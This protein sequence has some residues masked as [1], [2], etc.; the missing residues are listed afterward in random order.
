V[1]LQAARD[2]HLPESLREVGFSDTQV[3]DALISIVNRC[4]EPVSERAL[5]QWL[6]TSALGD[7]WKEDLENLGRDRFYRVSDALLRV[8][9]T[10]EEKLAQREQS[11][12]GLER[13]LY[14]Y[15]LTNTYF[16]GN[17]HKN[18]AAKRGNSKEKRS[19]NPLMSVGLVLDGDGFVVRHQSL[20]GNVY[21]A[22]TLLE[23]VRAVTK[24]SDEKPLIIMDS[25]FS[26]RANLAALRKEGY[27]YVTVAKRP[28]RLAYADE[29]ADLSGFRK[30]RGRDSRFSRR[31]K[32]D[33]FV[34]SLRE[35]D[36]T[37]LCVYS[38]DRENKERA[39]F[40]KAET[41]LLKDLRKLKENIERGRLINPQTIQQRIGRI[42][43]RYPRAA[44]FYGVDHDG[45]NRTLKWNRDEVK[46]RKAM[47][48]TGGYIIR[49]NRLDLK[50]E[51]LWKIYIL[52][53]KVEAGFRS[54]K[55]NLGLRP[56]YHQ[57][58]R[59]AEGHILITVLAYR[60]LRAMEHRLRSR[61]LHASWDTVRRLLKTHTY[62]TL[63]I[64]AKNGRTYRIR[65]AGNPSPAQADIYRKLG[66]E[67]ENLPTTKIVQ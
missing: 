55:G 47:A 27:E 24:E 59:R 53:T 25:G 43:E 62:T 29:F 22:H 21:E 32:K 16:E 30:V 20:P 34:K 63:V 36:E 56:V 31:V 60:L 45:E 8:K 14:L 58:Q 40:Q 17:M 54:L 13:S 49:T 35:K 44:R 15:D 1:A 61:G 11:V 52:L 38:E 2:I 46:V 64:P 57:L 42:R 28:T 10:L 37:L 50:D 33:V 9:D 39:I 7:L 23:T 65:R 41:K 66:V 12:F 48:T 67:T 18:P 3:R 51:E 4:C 26:T 6:Q 5:P 19:R